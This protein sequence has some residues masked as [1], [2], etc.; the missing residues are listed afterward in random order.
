MKPYFL[1][2]KA[3]RLYERIKSDLSNYELVDDNLLVTFCN[4]SIQEDELAREVKKEGYR[5]TNVN[6]RGGETHQINPTY[7]AYLS[8]V[9]EKNKIHT[10]I[11][12]LSSEVGGGGDDDSD[13]DQF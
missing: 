2:I 6:S 3:K 13:F 8:C 5:V 12:K 9:A 4:L 1:N 11:K 7:R 10:K